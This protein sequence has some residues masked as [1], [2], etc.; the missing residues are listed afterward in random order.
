MTK[1][2]TKWLTFILGACAANGL[3]H[4]MYRHTGEKVSVAVESDQII[5]IHYLL[6]FVPLLLQQ[7]PFLGLKNCAIFIFF[8]ALRSP[9]EEIGGRSA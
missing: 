6:L 8:F 1:L 4:T 9:T 3:A 7:F 2:K 5:Q